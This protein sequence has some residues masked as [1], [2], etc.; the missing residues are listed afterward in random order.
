MCC[1]Y[2]ICLIKYVKTVKTA[3]WNILQYYCM[4]KRNKSGQ[5]FFYKYGEIKMT[6]FFDVLP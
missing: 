1:L 5:V 2:L 4:Q 3:G 6:I